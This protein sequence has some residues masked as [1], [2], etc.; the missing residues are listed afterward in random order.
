M[1]RAHAHPLAPIVRSIVAITVLVLMLLVAVPAH[2]QCDPYSGNCPST[3]PPSDP[4]QGGVR[5]RGGLAFTGADVTLFLV[6]GIA[7]LG[8]GTILVR[9]SREPSA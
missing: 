9:R 2:A 4:G 8:L 6:A 1:R 3:E 7:A 5:A